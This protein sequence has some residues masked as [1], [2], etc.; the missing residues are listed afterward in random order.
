MRFFNNNKKY[1]L[2]AILLHWL[3]FILV[4]YILYLGTIMV[5]MP[6]SPEKFSNYSLHKSLGITILVITLVRLCWKLINKTPKLPLFMD[7]KQKLIANIMHYIFY[8]MLVGLPLLGWAM[9]SAAGFS[10][11]VFGQIKLPALTSPDPELLELFKLLHE[12]GAYIFFGLIIL[13]ILA[14]F[15]HQFYYRDNLLGRMLGK[16]QLYGNN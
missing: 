10:V 15:I 12:F 8:V 3:S 4:A 1:G 9:S 13:H 16:G 11:V 5:D 6:L 2:V 7:S 14:A